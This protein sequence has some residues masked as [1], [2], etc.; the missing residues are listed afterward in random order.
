M[1]WTHWPILT[2]KTFKYVLWT[3][4]LYIFHWFYTC[5]SLYT[6]TWNFWLILKNIKIMHWRKKH[7]AKNFDWQYM[8]A[9]QEL[10]RWVLNITLSLNIFLKSWW[11]PLGVIEVKRDQ[12]VKF[13]GLNLGYVL[14]TYKLLWKCDLFSLSDILQFFSGLAPSCR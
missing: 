2:S 6:T 7:I 13:W 1:N 5:C 10:W 14:Q 3:N 4:Y 11:R 12:W 9:K 8:P